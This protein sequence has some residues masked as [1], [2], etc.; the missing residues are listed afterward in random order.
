MAHHA[1]PDMEGD[2]GDL[3][4][5]QFALAGVQ[6]CTDGESQAR[7]GVPDRAGA[8]DCAG[9]TVTTAARPR[10]T[11]AGPTDAGSVLGTER[12]TLARRDAL[13][14]FNPA[15]QILPALEMSA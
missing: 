11:D 7:Y 5:H 10:P 2:P 9:W 6:P 4:A 1:R 14:A 15:L 12:A 13:S 3:L 8:P